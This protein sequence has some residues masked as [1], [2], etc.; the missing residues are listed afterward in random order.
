MQSHSHVSGP[1]QY[2][3]Y[4]IWCFSLESRNVE[5]SFDSDEHRN[6]ADCHVRPHALSHVCHESH[7]IIKQLCPLALSGCGVEFD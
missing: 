6:F 2:F 5:V 1:C 3:R 7:N 4:A